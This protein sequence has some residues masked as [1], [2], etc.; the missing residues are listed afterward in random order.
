[1]DRILLRQTYSH[2]APIILAIRDVTRAQTARLQFGLVHAGST[3]YKSMV[4][5]HFFIAIWFPAPRYQLRVAGH[6]ERRIAGP[7]RIAD[8]RAHCT[9]DAH[10]LGVVSG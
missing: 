5:R 3:E 9:E 6:E 4:T 2:C 1:M 10:E 7:Q 8:V